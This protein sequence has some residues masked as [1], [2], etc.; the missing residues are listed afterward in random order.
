M[1]DEE[2]ETSDK[3]NKKVR[4]K[5][6]QAYEYVNMIYKML[7]DNINPLLIFF[8]VLSKGY[9]GT[10][11]ALE[12][13][14]RAISKNNFNKTFMIKYNKLQ[15][16]NGSIVIKRFEI[17]KY[18]TANKKE[19]EDIK[20][21]YEAII[22]KYPIVKTITEIYD[23]FHTALMGNDTTKMDDFIK[24]YEDKVDENGNENKSVVSSF[25]ESIKK[26][27]VPVKNSISFSESSGF[28]EG[29]NCK[30]KL[31]KRILYGRSKLVNLFRKCY[32]SFLIFKPN[33]SLKKALGFN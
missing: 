15:Y 9:T 8:Y 20:N 28:V 33:F 6:S 22:T 31:I 11:R 3:L 4:K 1:T 17:L 18:I 26:D 7:K 30:F 10:Y 27:I 12:E 14:I 32:L 24:K 19:N 2:V 13:T 16:I 29:N 21:N 23:D 5:K 25:T